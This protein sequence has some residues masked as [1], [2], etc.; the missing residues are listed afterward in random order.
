MRKVS[1]PA[2][3]WETRK[4]LFASLI[5][6][7][8]VGVVRVAQQTPQGRP[9][10]W[11]E[12]SEHRPYAY[13]TVL[14]NEVVFDIDT[15]SWLECVRQTHTLWSILNFRGIRYLGAPSGGQGTHTHVF[16]ESDKYR[17]EFAKCVVYLVDKKLSDP[18]VVDGEE[19]EYPREMFDTDPRLLTPKV[20]NQV[21]REFGVNKNYKK[22]L[23]TRGPGGFL[24]LPLY[25]PKTYAMRGVAIPEDVPVNDLD[26][27]PKD[28]MLDTRDM[29]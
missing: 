25:R 7:S 23:W 5:N 24:P 3:E 19:F 22:T 11:V 6:H 21:V 13:R 18:V 4:R 17:D 8:H 16:L 29:I 9:Q 12:T 2:E 14:K 27:S 26:G 20:G 28:A 10:T 1:D 15:D